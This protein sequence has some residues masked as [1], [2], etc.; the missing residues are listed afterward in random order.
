MS[1]LVPAS[2]VVSPGQKHRSTRTEAALH[3]Q[4]KC[5][6]H[7]DTASQCKSF[8]H[9]NISASNRARILTNIQRNLLRNRAI[10]YSVRKDPKL[11][12]NHVAL[13]GSFH[14]LVPLQFSRLLSSIRKSA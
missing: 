2:G 1:L 8:V 11:F 13:A 5:R 12:S 10:P 9:G 3:R 4:A 6:P 7:K 14:A